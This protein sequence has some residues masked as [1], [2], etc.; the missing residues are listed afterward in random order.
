MDSGAWGINTS[1]ETCSHNFDDY[2]I[3]P[4]GQCDFKP[5]RNVCPTARLASDSAMFFCSVDLNKIK[6]L[7]LW[8]SANEITDTWHS[9]KKI[10]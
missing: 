8:N 3:P 5:F 7:N 1:L 10:K 4:G 6:H 9:N 2:S